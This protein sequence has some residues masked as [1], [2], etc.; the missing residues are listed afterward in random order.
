[1]GFMELLVF[2]GGMS[3]IRVVNGLVCGFIGG[4]LHSIISLGMGWLGLKRY[5]E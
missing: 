2:C 1:M 3:G 5:W 4:F